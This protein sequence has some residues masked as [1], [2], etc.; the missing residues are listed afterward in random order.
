MK[1]LTA[2]LTTIILLSVAVSCKKTGSL[3]SERLPT[4]AK[5]SDYQKGDFVFSVSNLRKLTYTRS[6]N[7]G[8]EQ[9][10]PSHLYVRFK[11]VTQEHVNAIEEKNIPAYPYPLA[12]DSL[13]VSNPDYSTL[14]T[15][16]PM[17]KALPDCPYEI[18]DTVMM[19]MPET[20]GVAAAYAAA[21]RADKIPVTGYSGTF[22]RAPLRDLIP[23]PCDPWAD[24]NDYENPSSICDDAPPPAEPPPAPPTPL[25]P[26]ED[27]PVPNTVSFNGCVMNT[28]DNYPSGR[29]M[30]EETQWGN[31][32]TV[33]EGVADIKVEILGP[34]GQRVVAQ[35][36][37]YGCFKAT[38][39]IRG[40][41]IPRPF[42]PP[43]LLPVVQNVIFKSD[44]KEIRGY[45]DAANLAQYTLPLKHIYADISDR[46]NSAN[47]YY[48]RNTND[49]DN[50]CKRYVAATVNNALYDFDEYAAADGIMA[51]PGHLR[52]LVHRF[53]NSG[54]APMF[55]QMS[56]SHPIQFATINGFFSATVGPVAGLI[57]GDPILGALIVSH[58]ANNAPDILVGYNYSNTNHFATDQIKEVAYHEFSHASHYRKTSFQLW[59][60]NI[61]FIAH[62]GAYGSA[63]DPGVEKTDLIEMWGYFMGRE[64]AHRRYGPNAHSISTIFSNTYN[65]PETNTVF[66]NSWYALN[67]L[68]R[69]DYTHIPSGFLH[70]L[71]D[72][73]QYNQENSR[74]LPESG[75]PIWD[76][77]SGYSIGTIYSFLNSNTT[78]PAILMNHL[79][80]SLPDGNTITAYD[81]LRSSYGY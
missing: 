32:S 51:P 52:I 55:H 29:I 47:I 64:Y 71:L 20:A 50:A 28:D 18:L 17:S 66:R 70:D 54:A 11:P 3:Q 60:D 58:M 73:N 81:S 37:R 25:M 42:A 15:F 31:G 30:V 23:I 10:I 59:V 67:E 6:V 57:V 69:V 26:A 80:N 61:N 14:Y 8:E 40:Y 1:K 75:G 76:N 56:G 27:R 78:S 77:V 49:Q 53:D 36:N 46:M 2:V 79:R 5:S 39:A 21:G 35:T 24:P 38:G 62:Y 41:K 7:G 4:A 44:R 43:L 19:L 13:D 12:T 68:T 45:N 63:G 34:N 22:A 74:N 48:D 65:P 33:Y 9:I 72:N 16:L